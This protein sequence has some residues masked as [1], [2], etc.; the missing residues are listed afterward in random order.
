ML[1]I[2]S[3]EWFCFRCL[4]WQIILALPQVMQK[5]PLELGPVSGVKHVVLQGEPFTRT[6]GTSPPAR[7]GAVFLG[8]G[9]AGWAEPLLR[10]PERR[11][12]G[13]PRGSFTRCDVHACVL[14]LRETLRLR[15]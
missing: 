4:I 15:P 12:G 13:W 3:L 8:N 7:A 6:A 10:R 1:A 9:D 11:E 2:L 5:V 14:P